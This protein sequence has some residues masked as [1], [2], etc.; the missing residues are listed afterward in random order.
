MTPKNYQSGAKSTTIYYSISDC[1][2]GRLLVASTDKGVCMVTLSDQDKILVDALKEE[3]PQAQFLFENKYLLSQVKILLEYLKGKEPH[4]DLPLDVKGT[5]FQKRVWDELRKIPY[6]KT[7][8]YE[9]VAKRI[10][11]PKAVRAVANACANNPTSLIVPCHRVVRKDGSLG[12]YRWDLKRKK[13]LLEME[14]H[15]K[16]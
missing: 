7:Y 11:K 4:C 1:N 15:F 14:K 16:N 12:G 3:F 2:L 6:G 13:A 8:S 5:A 9:E 10:G